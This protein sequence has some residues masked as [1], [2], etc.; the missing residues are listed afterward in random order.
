MVALLM[1]GTLPTRAR[2]QLREPFALGI[3][4]AGREG[5]VGGGLGGHQGIVDDLCPGVREDD[6]RE[7][8]VA[9]VRLTGDEPDPFEWGDLPGNSRRRDAEPLRQFGAAELP[10]RLE[11][12]LTQDREV[13]ERDAVSGKGVVD[14]PGQLGAGKREL[15]KCVE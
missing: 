6:E 13:G 10:G 8:R 3:A 12:Q 2:K 11:P 7:A 5:A 9:I 1:R 15:E 14:V 4:P